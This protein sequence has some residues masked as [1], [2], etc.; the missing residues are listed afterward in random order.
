[1]N[2]VLPPETFSPIAW[3]NVPDYILGRRTF[4][5]S[6]KSFGVHLYNEMWRRNRLD[7]WRQYPANSGRPRSKKT[8][9]DSL[10]LAW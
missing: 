7:K 2:Y 8:Q 10:G 6:R 1:M 9:A 4:H 5:P 3:Q